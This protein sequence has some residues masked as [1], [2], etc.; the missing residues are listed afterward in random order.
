MDENPT[1]NKKSLKQKT[2]SGV[3]WSALDS[4][5]GLVVQLICSLVIARML[6]PEDFGVV[7]II[8][9]FS[10]IGLILIDGGFGQAL[11]RKQDATITDYS[12]VFYFNILLSGV[13][14]LILYTISP[15]I[16]DFYKING[17]CNISRVLF[18]II[19]INAFGLIQNTLLTKEI[20]FKTL[21]KISIISAIISG[22]V[23]IIIAYK[24]RTVWA[25]VVQSL[26]MYSCRSLFLWIFSNWR[27]ILKFSI[28]SISSMF[29]YSINLLLTSLLGT[30][31]NNI[32]PLVVGKIYS[33][34]QLGYFSQA[35]KLQKL[36]SSTITTII[37]RVTF[38]VL[39]NVQHDDKRLIS[40][41]ERLLSVTV[42]FVFPIMIALVINADNIFLSLLGE[43]WMTSAYYFQILC[44]AGMFYPV[45]SLSLN[46]I[47]I[48]GNSKLLFKLEALRRSIFV[49]IILISMNFN[50][51]FFVWMQVVY[52]VLVVF[53][54]LYFSGR[55]VRESFNNQLLSFMP[56]LL[57]STLMGLP[58]YALN[59]LYNILGLSSWIFIFNSLIYF[60]IFWI[61]A[62]VLHMKS[63][64]EANSIMKDLLGRQNEF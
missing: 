46:L 52:S 22:V 11:I 5:S 53:I 28:H 12:S 61:A 30:I 2:V 9:V 21:C 64:K 3:I 31:V 6:T 43:K 62:R 29:S 57:L 8:T 39:V 27:P 7:G 16:E 35:D 59:Y 55:Q 24:Y 63:Q 42:F 17:L 25:L 58:F 20:N 60:F 33:P 50:I 45:H 26:V 19:P 48:K 54:N 13:V 1:P 23:G 36:P 34:T 40:S 56:E 4:M 14:Y 15:F 10:A 51:S 38:P 32:C 47:N 44:F 49:I 18:L 37:Q 41:Y